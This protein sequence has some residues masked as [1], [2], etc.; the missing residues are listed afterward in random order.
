M[1]HLQFDMSKPRDVLAMGRSGVDLFPDQFGPMNQVVSFTKYI[2]GSPANTAVQMAKMGIDVAFLSK[3]SQ[4]NFGQY[5]KYYLDS[6]GVDVSHMTDVDDP[7]IRH[8]LAV[9]EQPERGS[10]NYFFYRGDPADLHLSMEDVDEGF[11]AQF[12][13]LLFS[14]SS[15]CR[16]PAR[17]AVLLAIE[18]ARRN[19]VRVLFDPDYR[20]SAWK[21]VDEAALYYWISAIKSDM[22][23]ATREELDVIERIYQP[24]NTDDAKTAQL[25]LNYAPD[26]V[27]IKLGD[28]GSNVY[29]KNGAV[30]H[31]DIYPA[32]LYKSLGA[33][34]SFAG[35]FIS[36]IVQDK[37]VEEAL[38][39]GAA[40]A[41]LTISGRACAASMPILSQV[42]DYMEYC[43]RG[44]AD[45]WPGWKT[46]Q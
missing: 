39:Y 43:R 5:V 45:D 14:G 16:G 46:W 2:G 3:A 24:G 30:L 36:R 8:S 19:N 7:S 37:S 35:A 13:A 22:I 44:K 9:A 15:L 18:Y 42:E 29:L 32:H 26:M 6:Q 40:S 20:P 38:C 25:L 4:D 34:D 12:K 23:F 1:N 11:I 33:G 10:I 27:C 21:S 31:G 17:E 28:K 41:S